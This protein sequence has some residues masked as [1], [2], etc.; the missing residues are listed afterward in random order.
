MTVPDKVISEDATSV[1]RDADVTVSGRFV[2]PWERRVVARLVRVVVPI[3]WV[4]AIEGS[5]MLGL[6]G[7][8][9][10]ARRVVPG[11]AGV[12]SLEG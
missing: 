8:D 12:K 7:P 2:G 5:N 10:E 4:A 1:G 11:P 6:V 3:V 9:V